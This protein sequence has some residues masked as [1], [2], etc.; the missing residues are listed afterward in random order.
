MD[1]KLTNVELMENNLVKFAKTEQKTKSSKP[2]AKQVKKAIKT[3][4]AYIG[5]DPNREG[6]LDSPERVKEAYKELFAGYHQNPKEILS[7]T[8]QDVSDYNDIVLLRDINFY[9]HC[10]HHLVPFFGKANIA[11]IPNKRI[12]GLS[13]LA[14]LLD[15][16]ARRLQ[17]QENLTSQIIEAINIHL[18][19][20]GVAV[21]LEAE[22]MCMSMRGVKKPSVTT[23]TQKFSGK[24]ADIDS[25][26]E[27]FFQLINGAK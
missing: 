23:I 2:S 18:D 8:F 27:R 3:I 22:H 6:V 12:V 14:R 20:Q 21:Q 4:I 1:A 19:P 10:E 5:D 16:F 26:R 13:K 11:Y 9:S 24:F 7:K 25:E 17:T 15:C